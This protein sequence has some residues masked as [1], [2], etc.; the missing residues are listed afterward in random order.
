MHK[1]CVCTIG[2]EILIGQIVDTNSAHISR[3]LNKIGIK[4]E[5]MVS[6]QDD[7]SEIE[8]VVS[9]LTEKYDVV[10][11][12]GGLGP[13]KDDI[14][15]DVLFNISKSKSYVYNQDQFDV[16]KSICEKRGLELTDINRNQAL[17]PDNA[18]V[19][20]NLKGTA[21]GMCF[22]FENRETESGLSLLFSLPGVPF[23]MEHLM[24]K[25]IPFIESKL[26]IDGIFHRTLVTYGIPESVLSQ[27]IEQWELALPKSMKLAYLPNPLIGV[28]LRLSVYGMS[29]PQAEFIVNQEVEKLKTIIGVAIYG[30]NED[31]LEKVI[32]KLLESK[33]L[34]L[35]IAESCTGGKISS[36]IT[37]VPGSSTVYKGGI[38]AYSNELKTNVLGVS[39][40]IIE[41]N[42]AVSEECV[43]EM[44]LGV[45][46]LTKS[47][48]AIATSGIAGPGGGA[49]HK[50]V[51]LVWFAVVVGNEVFTAKKIFTGDRQRIIERSSSDAINLLRLKL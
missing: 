7:Q 14:T 35:A 19:F 49:D 18:K 44:A 47:D 31:T 51:G 40:E 29:T 21:P 23:E 25:I 45:Q 4:V 12:T 5:K 42:G 36:L 2:D 39:P 17:V 22:I 26:K 30:E 20:T 43:R 15:K 16:I 24:E 8:S 32:L 34:T 38:T 10:I 27:T 28:R 9:K 46:R 41:K 6:I 50:P 11:V 37:S 48:C 13:T 1:A 33:G 3:L